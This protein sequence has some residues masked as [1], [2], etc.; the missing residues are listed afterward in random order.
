M[1][2]KSII[3]ASLLILLLN[4][5]CI[6][7]FSQ[8]V[9][10]IQIKC[11]PGAMVLLDDNFVGNTSSELKGLILQDV[12]VGSHQIKIVKEGFQSQS[13]RVDLKANE[14]YVY[15]VKEF[16]P[17]VDVKQAGEADTDII[18]QKVGSLLIETIP[19]ECII[20]IPDLYIDENNQG[21][22]TLKTWQI[23]SIPVGNYKVNFISLG[24]K[25]EYSFEIEEGSKK[26]LLINIIK[27]EV[28]EI[29]PPLTIG[30]KGPAGGWIFYDK[31]NYSD[32]WQ[33]LE[34]APASTE[35][36]ERTWGSNGTFIGGT[37][38]DIGTG[39]SNTTIIVAWL[40]RQG[41][42]GKAAQVCDALVVENNGV[43]YSDWF[44]PSKV[45]LNLMYEN[46]C[47]ENVGSFADYYYWSSSEY[48]ASIAWLQG[49][50][51]S[52]QLSYDKYS[53][54]RV[55]AVRAF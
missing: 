42:A 21:D 53:N 6:C 20:E 52:Y 48:I 32:G 1:K 3:F 9:G 19:V 7:I 40:N 10:Y 38:E 50:S 55:R 47:R 44:L 30:D 37:K 18:R 43:K 14:I 17:K 33:Y 13:V 35:W 27:N 2:H 28:K 41:E 16:I 5:M 31:G 34:A 22:K 39:K 24:K 8:D 26:H 51:N 45:E 15:E 12:P 25:V 36:T 54:L 23:P 4:L 46:L 49:F 29:L 11:E